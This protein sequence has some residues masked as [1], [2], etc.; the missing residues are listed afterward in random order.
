MSIKRA[1][2]R[3]N[4]ICA[5]VTNIHTHLQPPQKELFQQNNFFEEISRFS[6]VFD[7]RNY[8]ITSKKIEQ[9]YTSL[10]ANAVL[11]NYLT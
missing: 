9:K 7:K 8:F 10:A 3:S 11:Y 5:P 6:I 4:F 1:L 2:I